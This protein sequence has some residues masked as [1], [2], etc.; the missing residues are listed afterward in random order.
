MPKNKSERSF[1]NMQ[2]ESRHYV[3]TK[4]KDGKTVGKNFIFLAYYYDVVEIL[5]KKSNWS[6]VKVGVLMLLE[7]VR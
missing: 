3:L 5:K 2:R 6:I 4:Q 1:C 7:T